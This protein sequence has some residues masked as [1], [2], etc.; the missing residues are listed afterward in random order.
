VNPPPRRRTRRIVLRALAGALGAPLVAPG[1][2]AATLPVSLDAPEPIARLHTATAEGLLA[3][4]RAGRLWQREGRAWRVRGEGLDPRAPI[5]SAHG[6]MAG[7]AAGGGLWVLEGGRT[8]QVAAPRLLPFAGL[9]ILPFGVIAVAEGADGRAHAVRLE[10]A[11]AGAW[12]ETARSAEAVL[13]DARP[14]Q[15]D[16]EGPLSAAGDGHIVV[17]GGPDTQ[18]Y[19]HAVL[20]DDIEATRLLY[21]ERHGLEALRTLALPAP[22]VFE[23]IAPRPIEWRGATGLLTMR[24]GPLGAQLAVVA[25]DRARR[26]ALVLAALGEAIGTPN[27]W[28]AG[29]TD[30]RRLLA[31]HTPHI[32]GVLH[33]YLAE[34]VSLR[35]RQ[36]GSG[37]STHALGSRELDLAVW[38]DEAVIL[39][40]QDRRTLIVVALGTWSRRAV[41]ALAQPVIETRAWR[42]GDRPAVAA[43][44]ADGSV[45][46]LVL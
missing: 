39:P 1:V 28:L 43:L 33:E 22:Y 42:S 8:T 27:R 30:G 46:G 37:F 45:T 11:S 5:A 26:D 29:T 16:L 2:R 21:L 35:S 4:S 17:L 6:R 44:L 10:P 15:L 9:Y 20:G 34:G 18:R 41:Y 3:V 14:Q 31:V 13:P 7:R 19:R 40:G 38:T 24:S 12:R 23:D 36:I 32:G 25:A